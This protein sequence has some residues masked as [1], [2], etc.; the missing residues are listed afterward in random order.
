MKKTDNTAAISEKF[1]LDTDIRNYIA[2]DVQ[3]MLKRLGIKTVVGYNIARDY[4]G[5]DYLKIV[6]T[7]F[8][9]MPV[10]FKEIHIESSEI[11]VEKSKDVKYTDVKFRLD[12]RYTHWD[13]GTNGCTLGS[14]EYHILPYNK[15]DLGWRELDHIVRKIH[16]ITL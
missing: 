11:I 1:G 10:M 16:G 15:E 14:C 7:S 3:V 6:T 4:R 13:N 5:R 9:T 8:D 2:Y 12:F